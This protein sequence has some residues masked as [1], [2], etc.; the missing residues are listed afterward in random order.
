MAPGLDNQQER[1]GPAHQPLHSIMPPGARHT[2]QSDTALE[3][4]QAHAPNDWSRFWK[5]LATNPKDSASDLPEILSI[6]SSPERKTAASLI[7]RSNQRSVW[8]VQLENGKVAYAK[9]HDDPTSSLTHWAKRVLR[10]HQA[11]REWA[12]LIALSNRGVP[13]VHPIAIVKSAMRSGDYRVKEEHSNAWSWSRM[14]LSLRKALSLP[15]RLLIENLESRAPGNH[16]NSTGRIRIV[17]QQSQPRIC[18]PRWPPR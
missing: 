15:G 9:V 18:T 4:S 14:D 3:N 8:R 6:L 5:V 11:Y 2:A 17:G 16:G 7:K 1:P 13:A 10:L 12:T